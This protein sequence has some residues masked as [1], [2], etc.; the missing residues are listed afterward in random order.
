MTA[1]GVVEGKASLRSVVFV[2]DA[3]GRSRTLAM[4]GDLEFPHKGA[5]QSRESDHGEHAIVDMP[6]DVDMVGIDRKVLTFKRIVAFHQYALKLHVVGHGHTRAGGGKEF[7]RNGRHGASFFVENN[8]ARTRLEDACA[9]TVHE[10]IA[11]D[12]ISA[13]GVVRDLADPLPVD[14][15]L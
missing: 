6:V 10:M 7:F 2:I 5:S 13:D 9:V 1:F 4:I 8:L 11:V 12:E 15:H 3:D 14:G